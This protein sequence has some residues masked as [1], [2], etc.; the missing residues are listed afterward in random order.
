MEE[1]TSKLIRALAGQRRVRVLGVDLTHVAKEMCRAHKLSGDA[2][3]LASESLVATLLMSG[4]IKGK[5]RL[6][7]QIHFD[8][9]SGSFMGEV[10]ATLNVRGM[11]KPARLTR[12]REEKLQGTVLAIKH[13]ASKELYRGI[14]HL[15]HTSIEGALVEHFETSAQLD[16][17]IRIGVRM[18]DEGLPDWAGGIVLE[19]MPDEDY[20]EDL[21]NAQFGTLRDKPIEE[22]MGRLQDGWLGAE[23]MDVVEIWKVRW[24]CKCSAQRVKNTLLGLGLDVLKEIQEDPGY[25]AVTCHFCGHTYRIEAPEIQGLI[26][27]IHALR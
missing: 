7:L 11:M 22:G 24:K 26:E 15:K 12:D 27:D 5:E 3:E 25:A 6:T 21:F 8:Q 19:K 18:G 4:Q 9:F 10:D 14:T 20:T 16:V 17:I 13:N 1:V 2:A 23:E